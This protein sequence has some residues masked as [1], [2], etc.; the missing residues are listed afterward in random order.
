MGFGIAT[1][2]SNDDGLRQPNIW[3][4]SQSTYSSFFALILLSSFTICGSVTLMLQ[5]I[6]RRK[7]N[8]HSSPDEMIKN[9][10]EN[11]CCG[12]LQ[13]EI[14]SFKYRNCWLFVF[15]VSLLF[16]FMFI[17]DIINYAIA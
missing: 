4:M 8:L 11:E 13:Y 1:D 7:K 14:L 17:L 10:I 5:W 9:K 16:N 3:I 15:L 2:G 6:A 12:L